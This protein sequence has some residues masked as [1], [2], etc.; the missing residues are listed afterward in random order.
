MKE[1]HMPNF[2]IRR[3]LREPLFHFFLLGVGIFALYGSVN[4]DKLT[5]VASERIVIDTQD[6]DRLVQ[7]FEATWRRPPTRPELQGLVEAQVREEVLVREALALGLDQGD[8]IIRNRLAQKMTF[9]TTSVAQSMLP[10]DE[11]LISH[12]ETN[13]DRFTMPDMLAFDQIALPSGADADATLATLNAGTE[14]EEIGGRSLLPPNMNLSS[15]QAIDSTF[16]RGFYE[17]LIELPENVWV[18]PVQSGYG[19]HLVRLTDRREPSLP[20]FEVIRDQVLADWRRDQTDTLT[21][22]QFEAFRAKYDIETPSPEA[23]AQWSVQ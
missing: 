8:G 23:L 1:A 21:A 14:P 4:P 16:G 15:G 18:G 11:V 3:I 2:S 7:Q 10:E 22:A 13:R 17:A 19:A 5:G 20:P 6:I 9:L 12:M